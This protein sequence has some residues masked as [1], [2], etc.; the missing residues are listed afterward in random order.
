MWER[1]YLHLIYVSAVIFADRN[2]LDPLFESML[3]SQQ[4]ASDKQMNQQIRKNTKF[5]NYV[6]VF[7]VIVIAVH[8]N[9]SRS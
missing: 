4:S 5:I 3:S 7:L 9:C 1:H 8:T 6:R 2:N